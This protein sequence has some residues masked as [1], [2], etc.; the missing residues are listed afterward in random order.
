MIHEPQR[1]VSAESAQQTQPAAV[2]PR[3]SFVPPVDIVELAEEFVLT[4]DMPGASAEQINVDF[5]DGE[6][7]IHAV[8]PPRRKAEQRALL[9]E[10]SVGDYVRKFAVGNAVDGSRIS[11][12]Y[13]DGVLT[14]HL[15]KVEA[16]KPRRISVQA[17]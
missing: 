16:V 11:A 5:E 1:A 3:R 9:E 7:R 13:A 6:L 10:Y 2:E 12:A 15:P 17:N 4:A 8:V 14:L